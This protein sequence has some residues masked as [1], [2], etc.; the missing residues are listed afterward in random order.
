[1]FPVIKRFRNVGVISK[2]AIHFFFFGE[3]RFTNINE[4][5]LK[6]KNR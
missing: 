2:N 6:G 4:C 1:M 3:D 5:M